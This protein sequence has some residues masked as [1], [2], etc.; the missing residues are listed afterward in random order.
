MKKIMEQSCFSKEKVILFF[1]HSFFLINSIS[2]WS[3]CW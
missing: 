3:L 2:N 1:F